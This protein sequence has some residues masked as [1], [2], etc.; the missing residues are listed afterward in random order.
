MI[1]A[2]WLQVLQRIPADYLDTL[3]L[4]SITGAELVVQQVFRIER[5]FVVVRARNSGSLDGGRTIVVPY[6]QIDYLAFNRKMAQEEAM[7]IFGAPFQP[8]APAYA[9]P[10]GAGTPPLEP[11]EP[12]PLPAFAAPPP[13]AAAEPEP[14]AAEASAEP[15]APKPGHISKTILLARLRERL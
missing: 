9:V 7:A 13:A 2:G 8:V 15:P 12:I 6:S 10:A 1:E 14:A 3:S 5:D 4:V 11:L